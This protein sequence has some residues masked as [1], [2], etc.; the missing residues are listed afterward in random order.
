[1]AE[2]HGNM[3]NYALDT[4]ML[5]F[6]DGVA[7]LVLSCGLHLQARGEACQLLT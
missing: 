4:E 5:Y 2:G 6:K 3:K 7:V 1:M